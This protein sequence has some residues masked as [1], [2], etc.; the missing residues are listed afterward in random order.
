MKSEILLTWDELRSDSELRNKVRQRL[1]DVMEPSG[2]TQDTH[3]PDTNAPEHIS[4][5]DR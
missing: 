4:R 5:T 2:R 3:T 1:Q